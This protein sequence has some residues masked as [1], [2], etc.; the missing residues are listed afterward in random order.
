[1]H[2]QAN[3][4]ALEA[5]IEKQLT[6]T[7]LET[8]KAEG[9]SVDGVN[10]TGSLYRGGNGYYIGQPQNYNAQFAIDEQ[11]FWQ[12]L[13]DTQKQEL[14]KIQRQSD[15]KLKILNRFDRMIK[16]YGVLQLLKKGL[17][18]DDAHFTLFYQLPLASSSPTVK[19]N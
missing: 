15:W 16:K 13:E 17:E 12:F 4:Q 8:I 10:E 11:F 18:V 1:M 3:E 6:G 5:A 19:E 14:E 9:L 7:T 2:S